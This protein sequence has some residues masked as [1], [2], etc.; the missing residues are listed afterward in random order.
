M[1]FG[2]FCD[3]SQLAER[4]FL[5]LVWLVCSDCYMDDHVQRRS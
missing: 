3:K 2:E 1:V 5:G 4:L